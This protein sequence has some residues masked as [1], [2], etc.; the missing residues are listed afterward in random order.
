MSIEKKPILGKDAV[1]EYFKAK[2]EFQTKKSEGRL[3][4]G[5]EFTKRLVVTTIAGKKVIQ[6]KDKLNKMDKFQAFFWSGPAMLKN[7]T[8]VLM[9]NLRDKVIELDD[10]HKAKFRGL[11]D[12]YS[13]DHSWG[14]KKIDAPYKEVLP[15]T[16]EQ[17]QTQA[18]ELEQ[19][20]RAVRQLKS[21]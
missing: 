15:I 17:L 21:A 14:L 2:E 11:L 4:K 19:E 5:E 18:Q 13:G 10:T 20:T 9:Q 7:V 1:E 16:D 8:E 3:E 12:K 6:L